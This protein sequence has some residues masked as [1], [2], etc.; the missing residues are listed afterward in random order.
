MCI[1]DRL[2]SERA[3]VRLE[4]DKAEADRQLVERQIEL[5]HALG[6]GWQDMPANQLAEHSTTAKGS[7]R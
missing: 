4:A 7:A 5:F 1:R 3:M 6:G 2:D